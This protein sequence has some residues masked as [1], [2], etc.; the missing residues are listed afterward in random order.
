MTECYPLT[1]DV[2]D[3]EQNHSNWIEPMRDMIIRSREAKKLLTSENKEAFPA[4]LKSIGSNFV[5][6][7]NAVQWQAARGW[8]VLAHSRGFRDWWA[9]KAVFV[10]RYARNF[11]VP[12]RAYHFIE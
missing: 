8:R 4:F 10:P 9:G 1:Q 6:N 5:W 3:A 7:G 11:A 2:K 12:L